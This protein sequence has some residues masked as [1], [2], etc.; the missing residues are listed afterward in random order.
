MLGTFILTWSICV[1]HPWTARGETVGFTL[2]LAWI[3]IEAILPLGVL[4]WIGWLGITSRRRSLN[5][6]AQ[7]LMAAWPAWMLLS[8]A[9]FQWSGQS[10]FSLFASDALRHHAGALSQYI[11][12]GILAGWAVGVGAFAITLIVLRWSTIKLAN[13][14]QTH[15]KSSVFEIAFS[16][17]TS[18]WAASL[19]SIVLVAT[20]WM[21]AAP[22]FNSI[23]S[24]NT[25]RHPWN[26]TGL[27]SPKKALKRSASQVE[28]ELTTQS[29]QFQHRLN[30]VNNLED[31]QH[32]RSPQPA[33]VVVIVVESLRPELISPECMPRI[34]HLAKQGIWFGNH[35][36][37]G[38]GSS[39]GIF[40][41]VNG[42]DA[43]WFYLS[44][45]RFSPAMNDLFRQAGYELGFFAGVDDWQPFQMDAFINDSQYDVFHTESR[46]WLASD[47]RAIAK[48]KSFLA[49]DG[50]RPP[51]L[52]VVYLYS[53]HAPF[54]VNPEDTPHRPFASRD[55]PIPYTPSQRD[56]IWNRYR[57]A[58]KSIDTELV[59][60]LDPTNR[61]IV[62][63]G[64]H[65]E[66]F[67]EDGTIGHGT[68]CSEV[69]LRTPV[70]IAGPAVESRKLTFTTS[71]A[72]VL[73]TLLSLMDIQVS[74]PDLF[75]GED[76]L[77]TSMHR[78]QIVALADFLHEEVVL[79]P[80]NRTTR[81]ASYRRNHFGLRCRYS[82]LDS[83][84]VSISSVDQRGL[85]IVGED[86]VELARQWIRENPSR[87]RPSDKSRSPAI[88]S[89]AQEN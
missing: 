19:P 80:R 56:Q 78:K 62:V 70:V 85:D 12:R 67:L 39:L 72:D 10:L 36:S 65:G 44:S 87:F 69:Q 7:C 48:A 59:E 8:I 82:H 81:D 37:G 3:A 24:G 40:S 66:S 77:R 51:R 41:L 5:W 76:V 79:L 11:T 63:A 21:L 86:G 34:H 58:A 18:A 55:Y 13:A 64:D 23:V 26:L 83:R 27:A 15:L 25:N 2:E 33:D 84:F 88:H 16:P 29:R 14:C 22:E 1:A 4:W 57:N 89:P 53:T 68:R 45:I 54:D 43:T 20:L 74:R 71:H 17:W 31:L 28:A 75:D 32:A 60:L 30:V 61:F 6:V 35:Y 49:P 46:D 73:P 52:A 38:N 42:T 9:T 47:R 50:Q